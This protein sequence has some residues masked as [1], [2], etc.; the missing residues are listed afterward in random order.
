M[1]LLSQQISFSSVNQVLLT[2]DRFCCK[3][4][5]IGNFLLQSGITTCQSLCPCLPLLIVSR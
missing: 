3:R 5:S 1:R 4:M 2:D